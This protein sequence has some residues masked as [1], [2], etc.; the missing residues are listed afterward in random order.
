VALWLPRLFLLPLPPLLRVLPLL[1]VL[2][3]P[4][5]LSSFLLL[6]LLLPPLLLATAMATAAMVICVVMVVIM[7]TIHD[8]HEPA[9]ACRIELLQRNRR[10]RD[11]LYLRPAAGVVE[12][13]AYL[14]RFFLKKNICMFIFL[15]YLSFRFG[16][17][18]CLPSL[19]WHF[20]V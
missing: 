14:F 15:S 4:L 8:L 13:Y 7:M 9:E 18:L 16:P 20:G 1:L 12:E 5:L 10:R 11:R 3:I 2:L 6:L 19:Y 17:P